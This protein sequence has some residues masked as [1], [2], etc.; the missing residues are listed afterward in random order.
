MH[1]YLEK[2]K[3]LEEHLTSMLFFTSVVI[4]ANTC[5]NKL[6]NLITEYFLQVLQRKTEEA[7]MATK[8]LKEL[9]E[10]RKSSSRDTSGMICL[11]DNKFFRLRQEMSI[12]SNWHTLLLRDMGKSG[13]RDDL[14]KFEN[15][16]GTGN[17]LLM[18]DLRVSVH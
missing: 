13:Y 10:A 4:M 2:M 12:F 11:V 8:K 14:L 5:H 9:L 18:N 3:G 6:L 16:L 7:A 1:N 17:R 15:A